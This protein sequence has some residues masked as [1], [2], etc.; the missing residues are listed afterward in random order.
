[1]EEGVKQVLAEKP[2]SICS[3]GGAT[4]HVSSCLD[5]ATLKCANLHPRATLSVQL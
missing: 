2:G 3:G 4:A 5:S 1:M